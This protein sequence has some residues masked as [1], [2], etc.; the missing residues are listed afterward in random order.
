MTLLAL[1]LAVLLSWG[2]SG[3]IRLKKKDEQCDG[4][5]KVDRETIISQAS[6]L[7]DMRTRLFDAFM[8]QQNQQQI[9]SKNDSLIRK[10]STNDI[11]KV[12]P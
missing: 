12:M 1:L 4:D 11:N 6:E 3:E 10:I 7:K 2:V 9:A 8:L 5:R